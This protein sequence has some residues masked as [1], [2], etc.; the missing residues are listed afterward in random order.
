[1]SAVDAA[2]AESLAAL[3]AAYGLALARHTPLVAIAFSGGLDST[4]LLD[5]FARALAPSQLLALHVHHGLSP[6]ADDWLRHTEHESQCRGIRFL[7][8]RIDL[9]QLAG[10]G[11][12]AAARVAR[13]RALTQMAE[14]EGARVLLVAQHADD[15]AET[16]LLQLLRGAG[17]AGVAAMPRERFADTFPHDVAYDVARSPTDLRALGSLRLYR[18]FL[19][20]TRAHLELYA[21]R[22]GLNWIND[23]SNQDVR[24]ARNAL[25]RDVLPQIDSY[26]PAYRETLARFARHA[27]AAQSL[28]DELAAMDWQ[29]C[30]SMQPDA[31]QTE[32]YALS[33]SAAATSVL[34][35]DKLQTL[36][37]DRLGNLLRY[38][39]KQQAMPAASAGRLAEMVR[40]LCEAPAPAA[41]STATI[42][43]PLA[44]ASSRSH[45]RISIAHAGRVLRAYRDQ[46][47]WSDASAGATPQRVI[48]ATTPAAPS[49]DEAGGIAAGSGVGA[50]ED[51]GLAAKG[52]G[53]AVESYPGGAVWR[54]PHWHG[55]LRVIEAGVGTSL[56]E[57]DE[58]S[59][60][61]TPQA[62]APANGKHV[63]LRVPAD[64]QRYG[65]L[66][67][68]PRKGGERLR[69]AADR[70]ARSLKQHFQ[71][72]GVPVWW[73]DVPLFY[74]GDQLI[75]VPYVGGYWPFA[76]TGA[77]DR[78]NAGTDGSA[79]RTDATGDDLLLYWHPWAHPTQRSHG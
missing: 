2:V 36:S 23:E 1:M 47:F 35:R 37:S 65:P 76:S 55:E 24:F 60:S 27:A 11:I 45:G 5:A 17:L 56:S 52:V 3:A 63:T 13:Y 57:G 12:E 75:F 54:L 29:R 66:L 25:R 30:V 4:V 68:T 78:A 50:A 32:G 44:D 20:L 34:S 39:I 33:T 8:Q 73:R 28:C 69:L 6:A 67:A 16:V 42:V 19:H 26:F 18:P 59:P 74:L 51:G 22:H 21:A 71:Q 40:Q 72:A 53:G 61:M 70:P 64:W 38:W 48:H 9:S 10:Q 7:A 31:A 46:V 49:S 41:A 43:R 77:V 58:R 15:Q 79:A 62:G 14:Q